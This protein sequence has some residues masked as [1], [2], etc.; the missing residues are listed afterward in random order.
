MRH[1]FKKF[2]TSTKRM[3]WLEGNYDRGTDEYNA[4]FKGMYFML[5]EFRGY[6]MKIYEQRDEAV[7]LIKEGKVDEG[8][9]WL[10]KIGA[11]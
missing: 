10:D 11:L 1:Q 7:K 6:T 4:A 8:L 9:A 2:P 5:S 3:G